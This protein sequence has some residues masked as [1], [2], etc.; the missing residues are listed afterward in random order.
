[1]VIGTNLTVSTEQELLTPPMSAEPLQ[2]ALHNANACYCVHRP[3][4]VSVFPIV[5]QTQNRAISFTVPVVPSADAIRYA[6]THWLLGSFAASVPATTCM[7]SSQ[8]VPKLYLPGSITP[9]VAGPSVVVIA[10]L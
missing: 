5:R 6:C 3:P 9:T 2:T 7:C 4:L 8:S 1:V 10:R